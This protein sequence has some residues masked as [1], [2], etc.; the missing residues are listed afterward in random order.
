M[1]E[2]HV[3]PLCH[4]CADKIEQ[5]DLLGKRCFEIVGCEKLTKSE[6][7][8]GN[9]QGEEVFISNIIVH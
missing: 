7:E 8:E 2:K 1:S 5:P 6:W 4:K 9:R 3:I